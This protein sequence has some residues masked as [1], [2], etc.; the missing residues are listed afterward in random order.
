V[1]VRSM[2]SE[3]SSSSVATR[4]AFAV[5]D[6]LAPRIS[7]GLRHRSASFLRIRSLQSAS[8]KARRT[9]ISHPHRSKH[10][11]ANKAS[12]ALC[13]LPANTMH[14]PGFWKNF[15]TAC[16]T[17]APA[18]FISASTC[19]P[20]ANAASSAAR[21]RV[22]VK[23]GES[24]QASQFDDSMRTSEVDRLEELFFFRVLFLADRL[25]RL[26]LD[27]VTLGWSIF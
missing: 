10:C 13:P 20:L 5:S 2:T 1:S 18:L 21:I 12:P 6:G 8:L 4:P 9:S 11:A 14:E 7:G 22:D 27:L 26:F 25:D 19:T 16:A 23:I 24:N 3:G 17:P 15:V